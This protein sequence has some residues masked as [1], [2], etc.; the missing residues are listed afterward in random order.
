MPGPKVRAALLA[1]TVAACVTALLSSCT[2]AP[3]ADDWV[4]TPI[5]YAN[6][7]DGSP[8]EPTIDVTYP[9]PHIAPDTAGG[10]WTESAGSWLHLEARGEAPRRF[11]VEGEMASLRVRGIAATDPSTVIVSGG[12]DGAREGSLWRFDTSSMRW[13]AISTT[14]TVVGDVALTGGAVAYVEY[15]VDAR[16]G[17][18]AVIHRLDDRGGDPD[19]DRVVSPVFPV[20]ADGVVEL[21]AAADGTLVANTGTRL[22]LITPSGGLS[23]VATLDAA[24]PLSAASPGGVIAWAVA[25]DRRGG[26]WFVDG[27]SPEARRIVEANEDCG[28][29]RIA[30]TDGRVSPA[31]CDLQAMAWIDERTL[32]VSVGTEGG[33]VLAKIRPPE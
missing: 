20:G 32:I 3:A 19:A 10:L 6:A 25:A 33:A 15:L 22:L 2:A 23:E 11:N 30:F 16:G 7:S 12:I 28:A 26:P 1:C 13:S 21:S 4:L 5:A 14:A 9:M 18:S 24:E 17:V 29:R 8:P 31:L 27:G